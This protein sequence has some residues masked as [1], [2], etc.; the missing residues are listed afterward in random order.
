MRD[1]NA[2]VAD[3]LLPLVQTTIA[4]GSDA[5][6]ALTAALR[7]YADKVHETR[8]QMTVQTLWRC[9]DCGRHWQAVLTVKEER[10]VRPE[11]CPECFNA[12]Q[13]AEKREKFGPSRFLVFRYVQ[14]PE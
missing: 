14:A 5:M 12:A 7:S 10:Q 9:C 2:A 8:E 1:F 4:D 13:S 3:L 6:L 11:N